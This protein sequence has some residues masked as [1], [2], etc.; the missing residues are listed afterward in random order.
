MSFP[1]IDGIVVLRRGV[2]GACSHPACEPEAW[3]ITE[4]TSW[5]HHEWL[6]PSILLTAIIPPLAHIR[7]RAALPRLCARIRETSLAHGDAYRTPPKLLPLVERRGL[8]AHLQAYRWRLVLAMAL[9]GLAYAQLWRPR[10]LKNYGCGGN[11]FTY[12]VPEYLTLATALLIAVLV[13]A[14]TRQR[15]FGSM[16]H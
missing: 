10:F 3:L 13:Q 12:S 11:P 4:W 5:W 1:G 2:A 14:P 6:L 16:A 8:R 9:G 15:V 7:W